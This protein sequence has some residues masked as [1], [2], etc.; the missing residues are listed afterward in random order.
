MFEFHD[1]VWV[2]CHI[3]LLISYKEHVGDAWASGK[4]GGCLRKR[5]KK[6]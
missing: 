6:S 1:P 3:L 4:Y 2:F 5:K